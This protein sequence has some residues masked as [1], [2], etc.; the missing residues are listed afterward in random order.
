MKNSDQFPFVTYMQTFGTLSGNLVP[1]IF[2]SRVRH[3]S[4]FLR[5]L[6]EVQVKMNKFTSKLNYCIW[7]SFDKVELNGGRHP[8][9]LDYSSGVTFCIRAGLFGC[10]F[11]VSFCFVMHQYYNTNVLLH[12][13]VTFTIVN[14][15]LANI[16]WICIFKG[17]ESV[18]HQLMSKLVRFCISKSLSE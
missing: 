16:W 8:H 11:Q 12:I 2:A 17:V 13:S 14:I 7:D 10:L 3:V 1:L 15:I 18:A 4:K 5:K 9:Q 6:V